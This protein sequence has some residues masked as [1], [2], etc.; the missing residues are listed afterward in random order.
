[1]DGTLDATDDDPGSVLAFYATT[2][3][4]HGS[5]DLDAYTGHFSYTPSAGFSGMDTFLFVACDGAACSAPATVTITVNAR[6]VAQSATVTT[7][8]DVPVAVALVATDAE[9]DPLTYEIVTGP[10][11][12]TLSGTS[13]SLVY[14]PATNWNGTDAF[15][16]RARDAIGPSNTATVTIVVRPVNDAPTVGPITVNP[17]LARVGT[18]IS[19]TAAFADPDVG[20]SHV[21]IW[22]PGDGTS[23]AGQVD[24]ATQHVAGTIAY[25]RAGLY[26]VVLTVTDGA[27]ASGQSTSEVV[28]VYDPGAGFAIAGGWFDSGPGT[29]APSR[30]QAVR[31][32]LNVSAMYAKGANVPSGWVQVLLDGPGRI[33]RATALTWL[34]VQPGTA[35]LAGTGTLDGAAGHSFLI[36]L[37]EGKFPKVRVVI[38]N[39]STGTLVYDSQPGAPMT[40]APTA[41]LQG[42]V[43]VHATR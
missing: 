20:D 2:L 6:P 14:T 12:G 40:A 23:V 10:Q 8:E 33:F 17:M 22:A 18:A 29:Y 26:R 7:N 9:S 42:S 3:P 31:A 41:A 19:V 21:A 16:F 25:A 30:Q 15:T 38:R 34:V 4:S 5:L 32:I 24:E 13:P 11:H 43:Q 35:Y 1:V 36:A 27:G 39:D 37:A 28:V